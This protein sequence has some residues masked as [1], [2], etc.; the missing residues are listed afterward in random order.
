MNKPLPKAGNKQLHRQ[1]PL[2]VKRTKPGIDESQDAISRTEV[3]AKRSFVIKIVAL[4]AS[5]TQI[6]FLFSGTMMIKR[7]SVGG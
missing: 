3:K 4:A 5:E 7:G 6:V 1:T 2:V